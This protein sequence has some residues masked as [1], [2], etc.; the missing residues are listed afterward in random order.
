MKSYILS[1][2]IFLIVFIFT[3]S[4]LNIP[5][6]N[7]L[8]AVFILLSIILFYRKSI[9]DAFLGFGLAYSIIAISAYFL[10]TFYQN[11]LAKFNFEIP[12]DVQLFTFVYIP[13]F[14]TYIFVYIL[15]N[16]IFNSFIFVRNLK[17]SFIFIFFIDFGLIF[18]DTLHMEWTTQP[19]GII[20]KSILYFLGFVTLVF[21]S[22]Y[23][24]TLNDKLKE[25]ELLNNALNE[26]NTE[27]RKIKHDYGSEIS[28]L[29]GLYKLGKFDRIGE[30]LKS[31]VDKNQA[32][33]SG[34]KLNTEINPLVSS[35][36]DLGAR[37]GLNIIVFDNGD[38]K[39]LN[40]TDNDLLKVLFNIVKN[41]IDALEGTNNPTI[42]YK[43]YNSYSGIVITVSNN[44][45]QIPEDVKKRIFE[46][47]YSTKENTNLDRGYGL[48]IV[49][50]IIKTCGG[51][52]IVNSDAHKTQFKI[53]IPY[54]NS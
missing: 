25:L 45:P 22:I 26:K 24:A 13:I 9:L 35:V 50:D 47:G 33:N 36:L 27:L 14:I 1:V 8:M 44:G 6:A 7:F 54:K 53:E 21:M 46:L 15:R 32:I 38:Y 3:N 40:I 2:L 5:F 37:E 10:V 18:L 52:I 28:C 43:S 51:K 23:F 48:S 12:G 20:F 41:A 4:N 49:I 34:V 11:V 39:N 19:M 30:L 31:I 16:W 17:H 29:Y 42:K